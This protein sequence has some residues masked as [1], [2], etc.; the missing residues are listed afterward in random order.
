MCLNAR[1]LGCSAEKLSVTGTVR[2]L[3]PAGAQSSTA[4][5]FERTGCHTK[6]NCSALLLNSSFAILVCSAAG[7]RAV[8]WAL[9]VRAELL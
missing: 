8:N 9:L 2:Q 5:S 7:P 3:R 6:M 1:K 4:D